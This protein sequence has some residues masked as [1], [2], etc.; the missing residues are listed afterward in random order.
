VVEEA[1]PGQ[2]PWPSPYENPPFRAI[3]DDG[4]GPTMKH[5]A[6]VHGPNLNLL[7][8]REVGIYGGRT[9]ESINADVEMEAKRLG[10][11][12]EFFQSNVEGELVTFI[13]QCRGRMQGIVMNAGA[14]THYS[15]AIRDAIS[16]ADVPTVEVH[17]SNIYQREEFR[18]AS[19]IAPVCLGQI[20]GFGA[21]SY[22]LGLHAL[23]GAHGA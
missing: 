4:G 17:L 10:V 5:F 14:Y 18:H 7:G 13:Q 8:T 19:V 3:V 22:I 20:S 6:V 1:T 11:T 12:V 9:M 23:L 15:I 2:P 21:H 16:A